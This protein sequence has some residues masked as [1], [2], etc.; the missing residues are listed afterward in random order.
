MRCYLGEMGTISLRLLALLGLGLL[1]VSACG[2][3]ADGGDESHAGTSGSSAAGESSDDGGSD[4]GGGTKNGTSGSSSSAGA[5]DDAAGAPGAAGGGGSSSVGGS[6]DEGIGGAPAGVGGP[7][8]ECDAVLAAFEPCGGDLTGAWKVGDVSCSAPVVTN[9]GPGCQTGGTMTTWNEGG[10]GELTFGA[11]SAAFNNVGAVAHVEGQSPKECVML[12]NQPC[13]LANFAAPPGGS[14]SCELEG[15]TCNC[16][17]V[18]IESGGTGNSGSV[19]ADDSFTYFGKTV[20]YCVSGDTATFDVS[21]VVAGS[22]KPYVL[23]A[24]KK[25]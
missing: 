20:P 12:P 5:A 22:G 2:D 18:G 9:H 14:G 23:T 21:E 4:A 11:D 7:S 8:P 24:T 15:E 17:Y 1:A 25:Q 3:A 6:P 10:F 16:S 13:Y 19:F